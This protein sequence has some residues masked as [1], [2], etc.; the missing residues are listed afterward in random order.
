[1]PA[2]PA[3]RPHCPVPHPPPAPPSY[4][5]Y[6]SKQFATFNPADVAL[7]DRG[8]VLGVAHVRGGSELGAEWHHGGKGPA[9]VGGSGSLR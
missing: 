8:F 4:G 2:L 1:M 3:R 9:K 7:L 6:G 5:A